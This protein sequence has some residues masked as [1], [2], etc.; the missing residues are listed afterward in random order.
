MTTMIELEFVLNYFNTYIVIIIIL[1]P[2]SSFK[3]ESVVV[4]VVVVVGGEA[5]VVRALV[6]GVTAAAG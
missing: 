1:L 3:P 4:V 5:G 6:V 2:L